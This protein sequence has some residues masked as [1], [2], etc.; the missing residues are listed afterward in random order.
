MA[1]A[2]QRGMAQQQTNQQ[3][4]L[5]EMQQN[6]QL[7]QQQASTNAQANQN[8]MQESVA[9]D[10]SLGRQQAFRTQMGY[11]Y[12]RLGKSQRMAWKQAALNSLTR[13]M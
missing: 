12:A 9:T 1:G 11:D 8:R 6:S 3:L 4:G 5:Q 13:D 7:R 2:A 10:Q